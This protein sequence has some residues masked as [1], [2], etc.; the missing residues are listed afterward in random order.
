M[1]HKKGSGSEI[2]KLGILLSV[3]TPILQKNM[4]L[5][6]QYNDNEVLD[7]CLSSGVWWCLCH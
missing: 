7:Y 1:I 6:L 3:A 4:R 5:E 2:D